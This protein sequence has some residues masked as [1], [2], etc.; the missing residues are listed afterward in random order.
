MIDAFRTTGDRRWY[1]VALWGL[2]LLAWAVLALWG[3]SPYADLL[4]HSAIS[5]ASLPPLVGFVVFVFGWTLMTVAMMLPSSLPLVNLF[6]RFV[7]DRSDGPALLTLLGAGYLL[8]WAYFGAMAYVGDS[9]LHRLVE[10]VP[11]LQ[12]SAWAIGAVLLI[13]AGVYQFTPLK[14]LCLEKCRSPYSF[15]VQH[16][17][18]RHPGRDAF[19][20]G[21][22]HGL[23]C[24]GCCWTLM[25]LLFA[26]G[27]A[28]LG[29]MLAL[30]ALM[31]AERATRWGRRLTR[32]VGVALV[33]WGLA[34]L[35]GVAP[36]GLR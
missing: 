8:V 28:N 3:I 13:V 1:Q 31:A 11:A 7:R 16:W 4:D 15:L 20:L 27:G 34:A 22:H 18:G 26:L 17:R 9:L 6:R 2:I 5:A 24:V 33:V 36:F 14:M 30:G 32:P 25:L 23:F 35:G 29:W 12:Q 19:R 21:I 10:G